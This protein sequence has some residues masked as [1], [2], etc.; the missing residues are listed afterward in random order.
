MEVVP[1]KPFFEKRNS[2]VPKISDLIKQHSLIEVNDINDIDLN[3]LFDRI[4]SEA[5][6]LGKSYFQVSESCDLEFSLPIQG[7]QNLYS[8]ENGKIVDSTGQPV[9]LT[10]P[11]QEGPNQCL[12]DFLKIPSSKVML[13]D[14]RAFL[15][16]DFVKMQSLI[17]NETIN[18]IL[19]H[20]RYQDIGS[21]M[22]SRFKEFDVEKLLDDEDI[23]L[24]G[25]SVT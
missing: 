17:E 23:T 14:A 9:T 12:L 15:G 24:G 18:V 22:R 11:E 8:I 25:P 19:V 21:S 3:N 5:E 20:S 16:D 6:S 10:I 4:K 7:P 13:I 2:R 1:V